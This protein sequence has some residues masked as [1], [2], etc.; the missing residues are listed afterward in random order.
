[1]LIL[2]IK[3]RHVPKRIWALIV[4]CLREAGVRVEGIGS[5]CTEEIRDISQLCS[6]PVRNVLFL[7]TA[8]D[9]QKSCHNGSIKRGDSVFFNG[10]SLLYNFPNAR[11]IRVC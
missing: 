3:F 2:D 1:M 6:A 7:H 9:L 4:D 5:F 10:R 8:G 11:D